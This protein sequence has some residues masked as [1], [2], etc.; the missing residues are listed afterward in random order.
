MCH[1]ENSFLFWKDYIL[2]GHSFL[3]SFDAVFSIATS[4]LLNFKRLVGDNMTFCV[5]N[6][7]K[8]RVSYLFGIYLRKNSKLTKINR[9]TL[10]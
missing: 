7:F 8:K 6:H 9:K 4:K 3:L 10:D 5:K 2:K 1:F